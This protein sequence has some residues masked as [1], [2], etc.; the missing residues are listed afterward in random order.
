[1]TS[2]AHSKMKIALLA[3]S[4]L[5]ATPVA[6][7]AQSGPAAGTLPNG[8]D[9]P[10]ATRA[11][12]QAPA[13]AQAAPAVPAADAARVEAAEAAL[14]ATITAIQSG[15]PNYDAMTADLATRIRARSADIVTAVRGFGELQAGAHAG[16]ETG[17]EM[18]AVMFD[19]APTQWMIAL[20][21]EGKIAVLLF[22]Q[23]PV[24]PA[25]T[26]TAE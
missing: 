13:P 6:A 8:F 17:A 18:F 26:P 2:N 25:E 4:A 16:N 11:P 22:R 12:A 14:R 10:R 21:D 24:E 3:G 9:A 15:T 19:K 23:V 1:M 5:L 7:L 20:N